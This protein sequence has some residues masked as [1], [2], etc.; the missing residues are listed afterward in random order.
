MNMTVFYGPVEEFEKIIPKEETNTLSLIVKEIDLLH[1]GIRL[2]NFE[3]FHS[4]IVYS[5]EYSG[6]KDHF[7][8]GFIN[9][10]FEYKK[11]Y[12]FEEVYL[13]NPPK[14]IVEQLK[15][16]N[17]NISLSNKEFEYKKMTRN[18]LASIKYKF[19]SEVFGQ[20]TAKN[21]ILQTLYP[22]INGGK[23]KPVVLMLYGPAGVGKTETAKLMNKILY[24]NKQDMFRI[25]LSMFHNDTFSSYLFGDRTNSFAKDL[26]DRET[27]L[28]LLDEFDKANPIFYSAFYQ[29]FDEGR[30]VDKY[31]DVKLDNAIILCTSNYQNTREIEERLGSAIYSRFDNFVKYFPLSTEAKKEIMQRSYE[32]ELRKFNKE[33]REFLEKEGILEKMTPVLDQLHNAREIHKFLKRLLSF[34]LIKRI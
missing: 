18:S 27:N 1:Q 14:R 5:D 16:S 11:T 24:G 6:V 21:E 32:I 17:L 7:I 31:Y 25:Q 30:F 10:I 26:N 23:Q 22:L 33:D 19:D 28:I 12:R 9:N 20:E 2:E 3:A 29:M 13:H 8:E 15:N 4:L 34:P